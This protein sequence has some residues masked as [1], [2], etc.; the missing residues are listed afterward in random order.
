M[1][2]LSTHLH[3]FITPYFVEKIYYIRRR[4][5][6]F[7]NHTSEEDNLHD[8]SRQILSSRKQEDGK[9]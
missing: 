5:S 6:H 8:G 9:L 1:S 4:F 3:N 2:A 7:I